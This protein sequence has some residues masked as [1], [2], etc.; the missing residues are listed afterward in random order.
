MEHRKAR[1]VVVYTKSASNTPSN[2]ISSGLAIPLQTFLKIMLVFFS[3]FS[4]CAL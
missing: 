2:P 1:R 4:C 3:I